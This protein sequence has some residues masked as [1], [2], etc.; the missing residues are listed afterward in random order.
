[1]MTPDPDVASPNASLKDVERVMADRQVR[2][3][4]VVDA[5]GCCSGIISQADIARAAERRSGVTER[6][7]ARV[8]E[9]I[10]EPTVAGR[11]RTTETERTLE[12]PM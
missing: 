3:V 4:V 6:E 7:V 2:R 9:R 11:S 10:S 1:L 5:D 12:Q 8:V